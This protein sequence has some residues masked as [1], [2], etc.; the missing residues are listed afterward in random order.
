MT[1]A[2]WLSPPL[3][4][5][6]LYWQGLT[7]WFQ[8]DDFA[9]LGLR[10]LRQQGHSLAS[11]LFTP[12]AQGTVRTLSE[13]LYYLPLSQLFGLNPLPFRLVALLTFMAATVLLQMVGTRLTGSRAAGWCAAMLWTVSAALATPLAW[14]AVYYELLCALFFLV[15]VWLLLRYIDTGDRRFFLAQWATFLLGFLVL[16]INVVYPA[17]ATVIALCC[18]PRL[19]R[20]ILPMFLASAA[21]MAIHFWAA[22][23]PTSGPY[24][25]YWDLRIVSTLFT[26]LNWSYGT[27]WLR[28]IR[29]NSSTLRLILA[30]LLSAGLGAFLWS[31][32][33]RREGIV[34]LF[35][36]WFVIVLSPL[37]PLRFHMQY[38]YLT[39]PL[40]G[41]ALWAG[42]A[43]VSGW[44]AGGWTRACTLLL[45]A[46]YVGVSI[47]VGL[48][49]TTS[50]H[51]RSLRI[52]DLFSRIEA[53]THD[54]P[55]RPL[56]LK[57]VNE[58]IFNDVLIHRA[59]RLI[60]VDNVFVLPEN[61][62]ELQR[63]VFLPGWEAFFLD[64][65]GVRRELNENGATVYD[66]SGGT[67][68]DVTSQY[69]SSLLSS[70][71][72]MGSDSSAAQLG[73]TWYPREGSYRWMPKQAT[74]TLRGPTAP[75]EKLY[76][77]GFCPKIALQSGPV[78][79][80]IAADGEP[81]LPAIIRQPDSGFELS[82]NLP[83]GLTGKPAVVFQMELDKTFRAP[84][85]ARE[86]GLI[87]SS[88]AI[89]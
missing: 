50:F 19:L 85:D 65:E 38:E 6:L 73:P 9:W 55:D 56:L 49:V 45:L 63:G 16:E 37:L 80:T 70:S 10:L 32:L 88:I 12:Y 72:E 87:V 69:K 20:K 48:A 81:L 58:E 3:L 30:I 79:I 35:P 34:L 66:L 40:I 26:Y 1:L 7:A 59:F 78:K 13:R 22:P 25:L 43:A 44:S 77:N 29:I 52:R 74:V 27:G 67:V 46:I 15:D 84:G 2:R 76:I 31:K 62:A 14:S 5:L 89:R 71:V 8:K 39:V 57:G 75:S 42:W 21:Y 82:F 28:L 23:L 54:H 4:A 83:A 64:P 41:L 60:G 51:D 11:V 17:I 68:A 33:R 18:A 47:P 53:T 86:L 61:L 24:K 36:A